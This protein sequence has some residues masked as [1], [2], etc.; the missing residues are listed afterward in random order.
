MSSLIYMKPPPTLSVVHDNLKT[1]TK[2]TESWVRINKT[3]TSVVYG[4]KPCNNHKQ[5]VIRRSTMIDSDKSVYYIHL[6][7]NL[8]VDLNCF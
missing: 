1:Y 3:F 8:K 5:I 6:R 4:L 2:Y 7:F